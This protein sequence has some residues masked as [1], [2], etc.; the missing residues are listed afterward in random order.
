MA[1]VDGSEVVL[2]ALTRLSLFYSRRREPAIRYRMNGN[3]A[4]PAIKD[5]RRRKCGGASGPTT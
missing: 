1:A 5:E 2:W 3:C 4:C